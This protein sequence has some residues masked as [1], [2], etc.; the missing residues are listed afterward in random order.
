MKRGWIGALV[1]AL[2]FVPVA[3]AQTMSMHDEKHTMPDCAAMMQMHETMQKHMA[4]MDAKLNALVAEM[5]GA[6]G[7]R[8]VDKMAA[9]INEMVAQR[10][11]M[12]ETMMKMQPAMM[13]HMMEHM[14]SGMHAMADCPMMK[15]MQSSAAEHEKH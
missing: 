9:V 14:Q 2:L 15:G 13:E 6:K 10:A 8:K 4:D 7:S 1:L 11:E 5:N 12:A 3:S